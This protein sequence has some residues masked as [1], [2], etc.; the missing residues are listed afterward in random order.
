VATSQVAEFP[1]GEPV[2]LSRIAEVETVG[3]L[4]VCLGLLRESATFGTSPLTLCEALCPMRHQ[5]SQTIYSGPPNA[6]P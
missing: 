5:W 2:V 4:G 3:E 6:P 1:H